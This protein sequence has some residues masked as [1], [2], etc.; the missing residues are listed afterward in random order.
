MHPVSRIP[1]PASR[2][3]YH[4]SLAALLLAWG[5]AQVGGLVLYNRYPP[6]GADGLRELAAVLR[7]EVQPGEAVLVTP[8]V[9][10]VT[11]RQYYPGAL[12][13]LP[14]DFDLRA[15]Y[16]PYTPDR[17]QPDMAQAFA[18]AG[19]PDRFWLVYRPEL[20]AG[21][22]FLQAVQS[23]YRQLQQVRTPYADLYRF[24]RP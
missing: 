12:R 16:P 20:D 6:H 17:S 2:I 10:N 11:L 13:G 4:V 3:P 7:Q 18:A 22:A 5:A 14:A 15:L 8:A 19:P 9:L 23:D 21:G 1:H 24:A